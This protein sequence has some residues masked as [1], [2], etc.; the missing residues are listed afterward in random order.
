MAPKVNKIL[1]FYSEDGMEVTSDN[2]YSYA[3]I[4]L[5]G[6][7]ARDVKTKVDME[8]KSDSS[9]MYPVSCSKADKNADFDTSG[10]VR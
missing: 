4:E 3:Q 2:R 9:N 1:G 7:H 10:K 8:G 5:L 6:N